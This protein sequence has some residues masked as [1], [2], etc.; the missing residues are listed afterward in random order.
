MPFVMILTGLLYLLPIY[1]WAYH[2]EGSFV[3]QMTK[4]LIDQYEA[5][6]NAIFLILTF[7]K[8]L[9][10]TILRRRYLLMILSTGKAKSMKQYKIARAGFDAEYHTT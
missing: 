2:L 4:L 7:H 1:A 8:N 10:R 6:Y 5:S 9:T 3:H